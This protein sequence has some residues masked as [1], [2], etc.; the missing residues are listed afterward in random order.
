MFVSKHRWAMDQ[1]Y[2]VFAVPLPKMVL[3][4]MFNRDNRRSGLQENNLGI[5]SSPSMAA[6]R[7]TGLSCHHPGTVP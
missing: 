7:D 1:N 5:W 3:Q 2:Q 4:I 6:G